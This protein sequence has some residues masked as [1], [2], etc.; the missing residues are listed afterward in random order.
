MYRIV[1]LLVTS[2]RLVIILFYRQIFRVFTKLS[3]RFVVLGLCVGVKS[4]RAARPRVMTLVA[5]NNIRIYRSSI[6][7]S[8]GEWCVLEETVF[9]GMNFGKD[10][11]LQHLLVACTERLDN[12]FTFM[13]RAGICEVGAFSWPDM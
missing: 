6:L 8:S 10:F 7:D 9:D 13:R 4:R 5:T 11:V 12:T 2:L 1:F 3:L